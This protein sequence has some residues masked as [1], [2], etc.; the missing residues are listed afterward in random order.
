M[1]TTVTQ[2]TKTSAGVVN[3]NP[4]TGAKLSSGQTVSVN[5][6]NSTVGAVS[7]KTSSTP[8]GSSNPN[9]INLYD[10]NTGKLLSPGQTVT[11]QYTGQVVTQGTPFDA[12]Q[13]GTVKQMNLPTPAQ[14]LNQTGTI[15]GANQSLANPATGTTVDAKGMLVTTPTTPSTQSPDNYASIMNQFLS[16]STPPPNASNIYNSLPE[17][18]QYEQAQQQVQNYSSQINAIVSKAQADQL[19]VTG[20]GRGI[21]EVIIGG[22]QAQIS[23]E[24]AI[25]SLPL[26][27]LLASAQGNLE[28]AKQHL[29]TV[30][31]LKMQDAQAQYEYKKDYLKTVYDFATSAEKR[32]LDGIEKQN[33]R[34][35]AEKKEQTSKLNDLAFMLV[36][37]QAPASVVNSVVNSKDY[38]SALSSPGVGNS[39]TSPEDKLDLQLKKI[40]L[41]KA[42]AP[43][44][45]GV[46]LNTAL[47]PSEAIK[48]G[49]PIGTTY[50]QYNALQGKNTPMSDLQQNALSSATQ[51]MDRIKNTSGVSKALFGSVPVGAASLGF[52]LPGTKA[53]DFVVNYDNLKSLL[54]LDNIKLLK[55]QGAVSDAER[56]LLS[57]ASSKL[58]RGQSP[59]E[60]E[61]TLQDVINV[62]Q[63]KTP[64]YQYANASAAMASS[65]Q[66]DPYASYAASL[67]K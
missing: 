8:S 25:Q 67:N 32:R 2:G 42:Q 12:S 18:A 54:S 52:T 3:F 58:S 63:S 41:A 21:P 6:G 4:N 31:S 7:T 38:M 34:D 16:A 49:V 19:A 36:K 44:S 29:D 17:K 45:T 37:N 61:R 46:N 13:I 47:S 56:Q 11:N 33:D 60:F 51:L 50:G 53:R 59:K 43:K 57:D 26:Q 48:L 10:P 5:P 62:F 9:N 27:A 35:Y 14:P 1:A 64:E 30:F 39:L 40:Q 20:Q 66:N 55:G 24:A 23:K 65:V 15:L 28:L 22:Q